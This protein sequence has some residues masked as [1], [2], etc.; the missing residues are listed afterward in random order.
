MD[1]KKLS[2]IV[3]AWQQKYG[4]ASCEIVFD[5]F[6]LLYQ[7]LKTVERRSSSAA[8]YSVIGAT[9]RFF[10]RMESERDKT[11][12]ELQL[13]TE[14]LASY[15]LSDARGAVDAET[16]YSYFLLELRRHRRARAQSPR[17][18][19]VIESKRTYGHSGTLDSSAFDDV[20]GTYPATRDHDSKSA[21]NFWFSVK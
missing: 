4:H 18:M 17:S 2:T 3:Q 15:E 12:I 16:I 6:L 11:T 8:E 20:S 7:P 9:L 19:T 13:G 5:R 14:T 10:V 21:I 1:P